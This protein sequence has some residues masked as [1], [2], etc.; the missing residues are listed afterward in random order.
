MSR[1]L[2]EDKGNGERLQSW[3]TR[4]MMSL[5]RRN[6]VRGDSELFK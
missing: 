4:E 5:V 1:N 6:E 3:G 2:C